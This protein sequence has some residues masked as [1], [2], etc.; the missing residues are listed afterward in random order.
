MDDDKWSR[1]WRRFEELARQGF[2]RLNEMNINPDWVG[3][4]GG[5][6]IGRM[7]ASGDV[8]LLMLYFIAEQPR[9][10]YDL[11][12]AI[13][14]RS[15][16]FYS[17]SPGIVYP[18]L[19]YLEEAGF[20]T[21]A[22]DGTRRL[23]TLTEAGRAHLEENRKGIDS[24]LEFLGKAGA[25][26]AELR[27]GFGRPTPPEPGTDGAEATDASGTGGTSNRSSWTFEASF[28]TEDARS[29]RRALKEAVKVALARN[30]D[31]ERAVVDIIL[32]ARDD[33]RRLSGE[34]D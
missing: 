26:M 10:G 15:K 24:I 6:R 30:P 20:V 33:I 2:A 4:K 13:E 31:K 34:A 25:Y 9:H 8:R 7:L 14:E 22:N 11:I 27:T 23:Y 18:A 28:G 32:R 3:L 12:K 19:T 1:N 29:A 17:P 5:L 16:G 21:S